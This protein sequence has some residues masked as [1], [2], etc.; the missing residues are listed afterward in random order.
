MQSRL[1]R[2]SQGKQES[3]RHQ[4][5]LDVELTD[6]RERHLMRSGFSRSDPVLN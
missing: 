6:E 1:E 5:I 4:G 3:E 2:N